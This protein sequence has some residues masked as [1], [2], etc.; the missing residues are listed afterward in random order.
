[1]ILGRTNYNYL[2]AHFFV[3]IFD[4]HVS[5]AAVCALYLEEAV[6]RVTDATRQNSIPQH[7][8][9]NCTLAIRRPTDKTFEDTKI[10]NSK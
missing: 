5:F 4:D 6:G 10:W 3:R 7:G 1:M 2:N 8:I 9:D